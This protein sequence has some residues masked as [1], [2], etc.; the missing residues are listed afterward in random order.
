MLT[1]LCS[2]SCKLRLGG[3]SQIIWQVLATAVSLITVM[4]LAWLATVVT[5]GNGDLF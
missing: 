4:Q 5:S 1:F 2:S 3:C